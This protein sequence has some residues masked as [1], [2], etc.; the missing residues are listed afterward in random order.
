MREA[1]PHLWAQA[2]PRGS[3]FASTG[4]GSSGQ[5]GD[6]P[7]DLCS[8]DGRPGRRPGRE[9]VRGSRRC[10]RVTCA[11]QTQPTENPAVLR[12]RNQRRELAVPRI[13]PQSPIRTRRIGA[14]VRR[15]LVLAVALAAGAGTSMRSTDAQPSETQVVAATSLGQK[16]LDDPAAFDFVKSLTTEVGQRLA[17]TE[18]CKRAVAWAEARLKAAGGEYFADKRLTMADLK[19]FMWI[20]W[21]RSGALAASPPLTNKSSPPLGL[22][23]RLPDCLLRGRSRRFGDVIATSL[24]LKS[25]R[26]HDIFER[27]LSAN[28]RRRLAIRSPRRRALEACQG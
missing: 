20:R 21:L 3:S 26:Q 5:R 16:A 10:A 24:L 4:F 15:I 23:A 13:L 12:D 7:G 25:R 6:Q 18:A 14:S 22:L 9:S 19:I 1:T 11:N 28:R 8:I 2:D 17:G 27:T